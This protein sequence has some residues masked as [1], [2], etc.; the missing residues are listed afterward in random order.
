MSFIDLKVYWHM[1]SNWFVEHWILLAIFSVVS[2]IASIVGSTMLLMS[3]PADYFRANKRIQR[4]KNP[5]FR[6]CLSSLKN[7]FGGLLVIFGVLMSFPGIPGQG[8][9][10]ILTG[11]IISDFPGK[12]R[13]ELRLVRVPVVLSTANQI[14]SRFKRPPLVLDESME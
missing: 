10:T 6:I 8:V 4:I 3:L 5:I 12:R 2:F 14:R 1:L 9:L 13:L 11:L 7:I